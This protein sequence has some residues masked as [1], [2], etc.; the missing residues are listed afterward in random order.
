MLII[1]NGLDLYCL[2]A[3]CDTLMDN[4]NTTRI[5]VYLSHLPGGTSVLDASHWAQAV[6]SGVFQ[7]YDWGSKSAN[8]NHY[9]QPTPPLYDLRKNSVPIMVYHGGRDTL[10]TKGDVFEWLKIIG[11]LQGSKYFENYGHGDFTWGIRANR[12]IYDDAISRIKLS[13]N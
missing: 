7:M 12:D 6:R 8:I 5:P 2:A 4:V 1:S 3:G 13:L 10:A 9:G 11:N